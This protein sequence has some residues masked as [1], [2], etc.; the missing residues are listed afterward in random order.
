M[1]VQMRL[2][3][4]IAL[5][6]ALMVTA[7]PALA[8]RGGGDRGGGDRG[9][10]DFG[11]G[12]FGRGGPP[13]GYGRGGPPGGYS[14]AGSSFGGG[15]SDF[16]QRL[17]TNGNG[18]LD[19]DETQ[20][21]ARMFLDRFASSIP[22]LD[23]SKPVSI[24]KISQAF[25]RLR[26]QREQGGDSSSRGGSSSR[27]G[28]SNEAEP[29]VPGF[30]TDE[31]LAIPPGFGAA[32]ELFTVKVIN[33]DKSEADERFRRY[34]SN[35]D[36]FLDRGEIGRGRWS[37]DP[38]T[39]DRNGDGKLSP[40]EMAV[41]YARRRLARGEDSSRRDSSS[42]SSRTSRSSSSRSSRD[43][44][45]GGGMDSRMAGMIQGMMSRY[46]SNR[47][48]VLSAE[49]ASRSRTLSGADGNGD[50]KITK[51]EIDASIKA[52][53]SGG[54]GGF[55]RGGGDRGRDDRGGGDRGGFFGRRGPSSGERSDGQE[56]A[57]P[58]AATTA[59]TRMSYRFKTA[60]ERLP[61]GL[62][63]W[64]S[65]N[66]LDADGQVA[67]SEFSSSW[68][69]RTL[70]DFRQ[71]DLNLDGF[72]TPAECLQAAEDGAVRGTV[73]TTSSYT[74]SR[75]T[76]SSGYRPSSSR[77]AATV[78]TTGSSGSATPT[79]RSEAE[80]AKLAQRYLDFSKRTLGKYDTNGD[81]TLDKEEWS[82]M[83]N[84]PEDADA[85][86]DGKITV[87]ELADSYTKKS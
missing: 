69:D 63:S 20:G 10:G 38:F 84:N 2:V 13:G 72:V 6:L 75:S 18:M 23:L 14:R 83:S 31:V 57:S 41:R 76:S 15:P 58:S 27:S 49:E 8:Q 87:Q 82:K 53:F 64:F 19:P 78:S 73:P 37:D 71:F 81:G 85:D 46:D 70:A 28:G 48:G 59:S 32:G 86:G 9:R 26:E 39:Y 60:I 35:R 56:S 36:G 17:D 29:L 5:C 67:M 1:F 25:Q 16:L 34:D 11:R 40:S 22:G 50:G 80:E 79:T 43:S 3:A 55:G 61:E 77:P 66:D 33:E 12:D 24:S 62:P 65:Q 54:G 68:T 21:R 42:S 52:R 4:A 7:D 30:G 44:G 51:E 45:D 47:D 74:A